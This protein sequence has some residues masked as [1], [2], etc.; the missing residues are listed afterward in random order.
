MGLA[1]A[2][3]TR[4]SPLASPGYLDDTGGE[5]ALPNYGRTVSAKAT[6]EMKLRCTEFDE[7]GKVT[8]VNGEFKKSELIQKVFIRI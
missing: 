7:N 2:G 3:K 1:G 4:P 6:N 5:G 8:L